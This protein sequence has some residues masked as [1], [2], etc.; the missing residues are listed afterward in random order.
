MIFEADQVPKEHLPKAVGW[1]I[2]IAPIKIEEKTQGG[3]MLP[4]GVVQNQEF[5]RNIAKV[6]GMGS[7]C[8]K[9]PKFQGGIPL[10]KC[11]PARW[12]EVGDI[13]QYSS[14]TG[15]DI[16]IQY[17]DSLS[18]LKVINDDEVVCL[19]SDLSTLNFI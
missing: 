16:F 18:K 8:Y 2:L 5:F 6:I 12:C 10:D 1:R 9:H 13:I 17:D 4:G 14:Y 15:A 7:E 19:I 11:Q 3:I